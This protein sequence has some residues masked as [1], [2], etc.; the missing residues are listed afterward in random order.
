MNTECPYC[1]KPL[2]ENHSLHLFEGILYHEDC[3]K[4]EKHRRVG[5]VLCQN[6]FGRGE[7]TEKVKNPSFVYE[8]G[9]G[10]E[11]INQTKHCK[12]C[13]GTGWRKGRYETHTRTVTETKFIPS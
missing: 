11:Y 3:L 8:L 2:T 7:T 6:C 9:F 5:E 1:N 10:E 12:E 4:K 13:K